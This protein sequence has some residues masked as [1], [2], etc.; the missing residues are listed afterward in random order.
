MADMTP[1]A[2]A[3]LT[4]RYWPFV[5]P[6]VFTCAAAEHPN[7]LTGETWE[8]RVEVGIC[9]EFLKKATVMQL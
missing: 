9:Y 2:K 1:T 6:L 4:D 3:M 8:D 7:S 5:A